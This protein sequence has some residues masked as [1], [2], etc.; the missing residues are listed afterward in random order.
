MGLVCIFICRL[1]CW[2]E[3]DSLAHPL[4]HSLCYHLAAALVYLLYTLKSALR[5]GGRNS[6]AGIITVDRLFH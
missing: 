6:D 3:G 4:L 2:S 1:V 5:L